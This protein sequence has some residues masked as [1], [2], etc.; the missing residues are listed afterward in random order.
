MLRYVSVLNAYRGDVPLGFLIVKGA[1]ESKGDPDAVASDGSVGLFQLWPK[2]VVNCG[3]YN[4]EQ[5]KSP[6][7]NTRAFVC[8]LGGKTR[9]YI[10]THPVYFPGG[11]DW[12]YWNIQFV[13]TQIGPHAVRHLMEQVSP[14][15]DTLSKIVA[16]IKANPSAMESSTHT[17]HWGSQSGKLVAFRVMM[18]KQFMDYA[19]GLERSGELAPFAAGGVGVILLLGA[20]TAGGVWWWRRRKRRRGLSG[21]GVRGRRREA[22]GRGT[23]RSGRCDLSSALAGMME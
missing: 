2:Q 23:C 8:L 12:N 11:K 6:A 10:K 3:A 17:S 20:A 22:R 1:F 15:G 19:R 4:T 7:N 16:W 14:G 5:L 18:G 13:G 9:N 21:V